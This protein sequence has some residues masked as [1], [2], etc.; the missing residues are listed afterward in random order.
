MSKKRILVN[1]ALYTK[2]MVCVAEIIKEIN[3]EARA[4]KKMKAHAS[5]IKAVKKWLPKY[6]WVSKLNHA[7]WKKFRKGELKF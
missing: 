3:K 1:K 6:K 2:Y 7:D 4:L 5:K